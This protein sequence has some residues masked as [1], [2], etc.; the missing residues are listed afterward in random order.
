MAKCPAELSGALWIWGVGVGV[1]GT[2]ERSGKVP[3]Q[4]S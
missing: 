2:G 3:G 1:R 4:W